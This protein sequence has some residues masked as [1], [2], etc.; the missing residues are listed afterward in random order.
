MLLTILILYLYYI[1]RETAPPSHLPPSPTPIQVKFKRPNV[2][3]VFD[4]LSNNLS[5]VYCKS[6][7]EIAKT[8]P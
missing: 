6:D 4:S 5:K 1:T 8:V 2:L 7:F 3:Y